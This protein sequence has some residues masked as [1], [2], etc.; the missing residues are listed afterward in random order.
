MIRILNIVVVAT[1][2]N[3]A[4]LCDADVADVDNQQQPAALQ[5]VNVGY[6]ADRTLKQYKKISEQHAM[7]LTAGRLQKGIAALAKSAVM[8]A[9]HA[10]EKSDWTLVVKAN[11]MKK[12]Y[13]DK[14]VELSLIEKQ[15]LN[16]QL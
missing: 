9:V 8:Y 4:K 11:A 13:Q 15:L 5:K 2:T 12:S 14:V 1:F 10:E 6:S 7:E 16:Q 3:A